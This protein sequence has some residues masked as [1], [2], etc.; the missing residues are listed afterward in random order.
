MFDGNLCH[1]FAGTSCCKAWLTLALYTNPKLC[2]YPR[3]LS[4]LSHF[5]QSNG[6]LLLLLLIFPL[7]Y[8]LLISVS[9]RKQRLEGKK[10]LKE[11]TL[12]SRKGP[13]NVIYNQIKSS[14]ALYMEKYC[15]FLACTLQRSKKFYNCRALCSTCLLWNDTPD[16]CSSGQCFQGRTIWC[17]DR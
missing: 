4:S 16:L 2:G 13:K 15:K 14:L 5:E 11:V 7:P 3:K 1:I 10:L 9:T 8:I 17:P 12:G 6:T